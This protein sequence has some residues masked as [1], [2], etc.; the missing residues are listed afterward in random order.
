MGDPVSRLNGLLRRVPVWPV[1]AI[2]FGVIG[3]Y[4]LR[5][6]NGHY[7][8][9]PVRVLE[10]EYG[11]LSLQLL[12]ATLSVTPLQRFVRLNLVRFRRALGLAS[13]FFALAHL[14]VWVVLDMQMWHLIVEEIIKRPYITLGMAA[15]VMMAPL[16][17]T[18]NNAS[19]RRLKARWRALHRLVYPLALL[20]AVHFVLIRKGFQIEPLIYL[21]IIGGLLLMRIRLPIGRRARRPAALSGHPSN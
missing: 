18:S 17:L 8:P 1:Y 19:I 10:H 6:L 7:L 9:D 14:L 12:I 11:R 16:A 2:T 13:F 5:A 21:G 3:W 20:A 4:F 15:F